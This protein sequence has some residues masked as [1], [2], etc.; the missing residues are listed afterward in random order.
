MGELTLP[1]NDLRGVQLKLLAQ[2]RQSLVILQR[3]QSHFGLELGIKHAAD[4]PPR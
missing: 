1:L 2:L 3:G 4:S